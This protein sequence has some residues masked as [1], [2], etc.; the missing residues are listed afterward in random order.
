MCTYTWG[1]AILRPGVKKDSIPDMVKIEL[2]NIPV[3][4]MRNL[5]NYIQQ[6][7]GLEALQLLQEWEKC[8]IKDSDYRN[9]RRFI[10]RCISKGMVLVS[11]KL[12]STN[13]KI[14]YWFRK[15][16][17]KV[18]KQLLQDRV[19]CINVILQDNGE[20]LDRC[21]SR[22]LSIVTTTTRN[23]CTEFINKVRETRFFY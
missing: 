19:M 8:V 14:S 21:R 10:L 15:I 18:G 1:L 11:V 4:R 23:R 6:N 13:R 12:R 20:R 7:H 16:I 3:K 2:T 22:L 5:H 9:H 17:Q